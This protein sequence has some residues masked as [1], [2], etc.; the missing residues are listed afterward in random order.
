MVLAIFFVQAASSAKSSPW[1]MAVLTWS[2][3]GFVS[4]N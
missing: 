4:Q 3:I 2:M 1:V